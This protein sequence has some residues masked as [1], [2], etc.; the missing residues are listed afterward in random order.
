MTIIAS[1]FGGTFELDT[2]LPLIDIRKHTSIKATLLDLPLSV[3]SYKGKIFIAKRF[4]GV[5]I[6]EISDPFFWAAELS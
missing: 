6:K 5:S 1:T 3:D 4:D 2:E